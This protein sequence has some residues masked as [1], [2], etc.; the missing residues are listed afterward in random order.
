MIP[1]PDDTADAQQ[2]MKEPLV[3]SLGNDQQETT[4]AL[5][6]SKETVLA[7]QI[8]SVV[9]SKWSRLQEAARWAFVQEVARQLHRILGISLPVPPMELKNMSFDRANNI[10]S[11]LVAQGDPRIGGRYD[12]TT[13]SIVINRAQ[14]MLDDPREILLTVAHEMRHAYQ[15]DQVRL[16]QTGAKV[17]ARAS[18]WETEIHN[19]VSPSVDFRRYWE[20]SIEVDA[21]EYA[22]AFLVK[23][24]L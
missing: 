15:E 10:V 19:P 21:R 4:T 5:Y 9:A 1:R 3:P 13:H 22:D 17:D 12:S 23:I 6:A 16:I 8:R 11:V 20:Q 14:L 24:G 18:V 7:T 2:S